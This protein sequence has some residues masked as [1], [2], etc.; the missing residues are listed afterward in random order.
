MTVFFYR[1]LNVRIFLL[2][3]GIFTCFLLT[4]IVSI[5]SFN[6]L[7][8][9][10]YTWLLGGGAFFWILSIFLHSVVW[11]ILIYLNLFEHS[12]IF[13]WNSVFQF[14]IFIF[15]WFVT[16]FILS[17]HLRRLFT[18]FLCFNRIF[19]SYL[20]FPRFPLPYPTLLLHYSP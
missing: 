13:W 20:M 3:H 2:S 15:T 8:Y 10:I 17:T 19:S 7:F 1:K 4:S 14:V 12:D 5:L 11:F 16:F 18:F 9:S 6:P